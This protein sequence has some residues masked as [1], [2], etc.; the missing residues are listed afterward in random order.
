MSH[1]EQS[2]PC[3]I[4]SEG[5]SMLP[6][7]AS[8]ATNEDFMPNPYHGMSSFFLMSERQDYKVCLKKGIWKENQLAFWVVDASG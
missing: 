7:G 6:G 8:P 3:V 2:T 5:A 1:P 4:A